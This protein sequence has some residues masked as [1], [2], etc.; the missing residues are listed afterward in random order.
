MPRRVEET[1]NN[2][3]EYKETA[4]GCLMYMFN[5]ES[6]KAEASLG[7]FPNHESLW[8]WYTAEYPEYAEVPKYYSDS[9]AYSN[10]LFPFF[11]QGIQMFLDAAVAAQAS[12]MKN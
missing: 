12:G 9:Y 8:D 7:M 6:L 1:E 4:V 5:E 11:T 3:S 10:Q 2:A